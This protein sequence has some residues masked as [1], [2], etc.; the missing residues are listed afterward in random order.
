MTSIRTLHRK[1]HLA[2]FR[3]KLLVLALPVALIPLLWLTRGENAHMGYLFIQASTLL[4]LGIVVLVM[5]AYLGV[6]LGFYLEKSWQKVKYRDDEDLDEGDKG[7]ESHVSI[8]SSFSDYSGYSP[9]RAHRRSSDRPNITESGESLGN[10]IHHEHAFRP[11]A[12]DW[13]EFW[14]DMQDGF[15]PIPPG[16]GD[17]HEVG[18][19]ISS[20]ELT[21]AGAQREDFEEMHTTGDEQLARDKE[22]HSPAESTG[23]LNY[24]GYSPPRARRRRS[25]DKPYKTESAESSGAAEH[26]SH[27]EDRDWDKFWL[28]THDGFAPIPPGL[29][30]VEVCGD[31]I[32]PGSFRQRRNS[33]KV[34]PSTR[35]GSEFEYTRA[36]QPQSNVRNGGR[37]ASIATV[38][39]EKTISAGVERRKW[40]K[41]RSEELKKASDRVASPRDSKSTHRRSSQRT[42][43]Q[44]DPD[45]EAT[46]NIS[47]DPHGI[48]QLPLPPFTSILHLDA[49]ASSAKED[50]TEE[51]VY[52]SSFKFDRRYRMTVEEIHDLPRSPDDAEDTS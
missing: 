31:D 21:T 9:P 20:D 45:V 52:R 41:E 4:V 17:G 48:K 43:Q 16:L 28:D 22:F 15:A 33:A 25:I 35:N 32:G 2:P 40:K 24:S 44:N 36:S 34:Y 27:S 42:T 30:G 13:D 7:P 29:H 6:V 14:L 26:A 12:G 11:E 50:S 46:E 39:P 38:L 49:T 8:S 3:H 5:A 19:K 37:S 23:F 18:G 1:V 47:T 10:A 51:K